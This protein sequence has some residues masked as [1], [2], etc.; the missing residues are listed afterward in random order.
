MPKWPEITW[1]SSKSEQPGAGL[2]VLGI[3]PWIYDFAAYNLWSRP[4][5][6]LT[7]LHLMRRI[8]CSVALLDCLH[9]TWR[10][11]N[12]PKTKKYGTGPYPKTPLPKPWALEHIPRRYCCYG[13]PYQAVAQALKLMDPG[14]DLIL[15]TSGMTY[16]Y[17]GVLAMEALLRR[18]WPR[19]PLILG[20]IYATLCPEHA[21][22]CSQADLILDGPLEKLDNWQKIWQLASGSNSP[23]PCVPEADL[24]LDLYPEQDFAII[25]GSR[26]CPFSCAYCAIQCLYPGFAPQP[27]SRTLNRFL[28]ER[29]LGLQDFAFYDDA[30]LYK[31]DQWLV[32]FLEEI[33][34]Q[35]HYVRLHTPNAMHAKYLQEDLARLLHQAGL[36]T[37]RLGLETAEFAWR[38]DYKLS[39]E[40]WKQAV[41][42][43]FRAGFSSKQ[44]GAYI[45]FGLPGQEPREI[46]QSINFAKAHNVRPVLAHY[47]PIPG[48]SLFA[49]ARQCTDY[50]IAEEPLYQNSSI[51]PCYPGGFS[52]QEREKWQKLLRN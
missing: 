33:I 29:S 50:P 35:G 6:L 3:N 11:I 1:T 22:S 16:W 17:P 8:G 13:L 32:P 47:S 42:N 41:R 44:L 21:H 26:G 12:W 24:A 23:A 20:G 43:L 40:Q 30:L 31:P 2:R 28:Q 9:P 37:V 46:E 18:T 10:D 36:C 48:S 45:L 7:C 51:W 34:D 14:P 15:L 4:A 19:V 5:G 39:L 27:L 49:R 52:W 38:Q 25:L